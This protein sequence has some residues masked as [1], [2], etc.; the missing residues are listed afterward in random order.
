MPDP[1]FEVQGPDIRNLSLPAEATGSIPAREML[2]VLRMY[3]LL[4]QQ[5][6]QLNTLN[7]LLNESDAVPTPDPLP[8]VPLPIAPQTPG[9]SKPGG[10]PISTPDTEHLAEFGVVREALRKLYDR[11][12]TV[13]QQLDHAVDIYRKEV[14]DK[15]PDSPHKRDVKDMLMDRMKYLADILA[16]EVTH[17][18]QALEAAQS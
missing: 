2:S 5:Q 6:A 8:I 11:S 17:A 16:K 3:Q 10:F 12:K 14:H 1:E 18:G 13:V 9:V 4:E 15:M 7:R